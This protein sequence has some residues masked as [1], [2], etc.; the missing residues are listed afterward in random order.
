M[1]DHSDLE[2]WTQKV[3][4]QKWDHAFVFF[5]HEDDGA[6]PKMAARFAKIAG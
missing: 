3:A 4:A 6:G 5:K 1:Y 2:R